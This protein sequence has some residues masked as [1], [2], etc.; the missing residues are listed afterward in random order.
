MGG[1]V[2]AFTASF[3][4]ASVVS[5]K[6]SLWGYGLWIVTIPDHPL[7]YAIIVTSLVVVPLGVLFVRLGGTAAEIGIREQYGLF[8][9]EVEKIQMEAT[10]KALDESFGWL[11]PISA[12]PFSR[13]IFAGG[14]TGVSVSAVKIVMPFLAWLTVAACALVGFLLVFLCSASY[15]RHVAHKMASG[16]NEN[17]SESQPWWPT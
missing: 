16:L 15:W 10:G 2:F 9:E 3:V 17:L 5:V 4:S 6:L 12:H 11:F 8:P 14:L 13:G 7:L 1:R